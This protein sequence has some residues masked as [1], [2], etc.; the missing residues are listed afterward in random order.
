MIFIFAL[1]SH[2]FPNFSKIPD[3]FPK[4]LIFHLL[5][6]IS[7][8]SKTLDDFSKLSTFSS[9]LQVIFHSFV[10]LDFEFP[11]FYFILP[12]IF[13]ILVF[14]QSLIP[15]FLSFSPMASSQLD[16]VFPEG[17][18][19]YE[20]RQSL[21]E[22]RAL[23]TGPFFPRWYYVGSKTSLVCFRTTWAIAGWNWHLQ[24]ESWQSTAIWSMH[25]QSG[26]IRALAR[27]GSRGARW[28]YWWMNFQRLWDCLSQPVSLEIH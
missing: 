5:W 4:Y 3:N 7:F 14:F 24:W 18:I 17:H 8:F 21:P 19:S 15:I 22:H 27:S 23:S 25:W 26:G 1:F 13:K 12:A 6:N 28:H 20:V 11:A 9:K 16:S 2:I 10:P